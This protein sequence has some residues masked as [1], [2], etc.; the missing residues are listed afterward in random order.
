MK[1]PTPK[2]DGDPVREQK[3]AGEIRP[4]GMQDITA[5]QHILRQ[6]VIVP[7]TT[8]VIESEVEEVLAYIKG[9]IGGTNTRKYIVAQSP[10]GEV[11]G[12]AGTDLPETDMLEYKTSDN[13]LELINLYVDTNNRTGKGVGSALYN[14]IKNNARNNGY[15]QLMLNSGPRY[16]ESGWPFYMRIIG[17]PVGELKDKYGTNLHAPVWSENL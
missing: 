5:I 6:W 4:V 3:F 16:R 12:F 2:S 10:S 13:P 1:E 9:S 7:G 14:A 11:V 15:T 8:E 17:E